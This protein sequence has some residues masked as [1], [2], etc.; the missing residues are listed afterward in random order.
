MTAAL[1]GPEPIRSAKN[2]LI[3][4][5]RNLDQDADHRRREGLFLA[6]GWKMVQEALREPGRIDRL[7][8]GER[9]ARL[10]T[11]QGML[12]QARRAA[13][14]IQ[15][16]ADNLLD[17]ISPGARDQGVLAVVRMRKMVLEETLARRADSLLL[18]SDRIQEPGN[19]GSLVRLGEAAAAAGL[20]VEPGSVDP[21]HTRAVRASAGSILRLPVGQMAGPEE[22]LDWRKGNRI[23]LVV[24]LPVAGTPP[25]GADLSGPL[26]LVV[27]N[28]GEGVSEAWRSAAD[29]R[30]TISLGGAVESLNVASATAI[31]LYEI[32]RQRRGE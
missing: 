27:G 9:S 31:L 19:L 15:P 12:R 5:T 2:P 3:R 28:E 23:R 10:P 14:A 6:W 1:R 30:V 4:H 18:I 20:L 13:V 26:A 8:V 22:F 21:Y 32:H 24:S 11:Y 17:R 29:L 25:S 16:V 7:F